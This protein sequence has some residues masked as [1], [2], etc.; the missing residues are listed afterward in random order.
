MKISQNMASVTIRKKRR[1][2]VLLSTF[3]I[4]ASSQESQGASHPSYDSND[5]RSVLLITTAL[6]NGMPVKTIQKECHCKGL[7]ATTNLNLCMASSIK[8]SNN[9]IYY[10]L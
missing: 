6:C 10:S 2:S 1:H 3:A 7:K 5:F 8:M 4:C 9:S